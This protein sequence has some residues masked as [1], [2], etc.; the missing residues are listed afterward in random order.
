MP[1]HA[2]V[3]TEARHYRLA[4]HHRPLTRIHSA[5]RGQATQPA[6]RHLMGDQ[7]PHQTHAWS[8]DVNYHGEPV[9]THHA[10]GISWVTRL[11][12]DSRGAMPEHRVCDG[13]RR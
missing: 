5:L 9:L 2:S 10:P 12:S 4:R 8:R 6:A 11:S 3:S 1:Y 13:C 7:A